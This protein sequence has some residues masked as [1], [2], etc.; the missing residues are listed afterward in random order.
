MAEPEKLGG[1]GGIEFLD[2]IHQ[3]SD[4]RLLEQAIKQRWPIPDDVRLKVGQTMGAII[5]D[6]EASI[7]NKISAIRTLATLDALNLEQEK[8]DLKIPDRLEINAKVVTIVRPANAKPLDENGFL[9][10]QSLNGNSNGASH[11]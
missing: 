8:R 9:P 4:T 1:Q 11:D 2:P 3:T 7:R 5:T 10:R 6:G